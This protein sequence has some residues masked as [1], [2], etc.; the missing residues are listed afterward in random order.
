[1]RKNGILLSKFRVIYSNYFV[2]LRVKVAKRIL[3]PMINNNMN[4]L[5]VRE[6]Y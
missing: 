6:V 3:G 5:F 4:K 2:W 1:M